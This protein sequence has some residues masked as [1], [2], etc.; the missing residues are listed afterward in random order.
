MTVEAA[1]VELGIPEAAELFAPHWE[2]SLATLPE[3]P[4]PAA[5]QTDFLREWLRLP[6][7][8]ADP[9]RETACQVEANPALRALVWHAYRLLLFHRDYPQAEVMRWP[10]LGGATAE[11]PAPFG[12]YVTLTAAPW[13]RAFHRERGVSEK[14]SQDTLSSFPGLVGLREDGPGRWAATMR[15]PDWCR[16]H[17]AGELFRLGRLNFV[18]GRFWAP[19]KVYRNCVTDDVIAL[20]VDG[21]R[22]NRDGYI[23]AEAA[24]DDVGWTARL[25]EEGDHVVGFPVSPLGAGVNREVSLPASAWRCVLASGDPIIEVHIPG[26]RGMT[27]EL[28]KAAMGEALS[29]FPAHFPERPFVGF[30]CL[31]W[32]LNPA[33]ERM[34]GDSSNMVQWEREVYLYP[35]A[36]K[37]TEGLREAFGTEDPDPAT[38]PRDSTLRRALLDDLAAGRRPR[39][40]G[41]FLLTKDFAHFGSRYYRS[42][43]PPPELEAVLT[44]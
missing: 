32:I 27:M 40:G 16:R 9:L 5:E 29:F 31:S 3:G 33:F 11:L 36:A 20:A 34:L 25:S 1:L 8:L 24:A 43:W 35:Y 37:G 38:A 15:G 17:I 39:W 4:L 21:T 14:I 30:G 22:F 26:G 41:M 19:I 2:E 13:T 7:G 42:H 44:D 10:G 12:L 18:V 23:D 6:E 28:V